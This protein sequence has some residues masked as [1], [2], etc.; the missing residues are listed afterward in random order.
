MRVIHGIWAHGALCLWAEDPDL[1]PVPSGVPSD[2]H[3]PQPH[4]FACQAAELADMLA[5]RPG[6]QEAV[7]KAVHDELILQLPTA[8][9]GPLASPELVRAEAPGVA[10]RPRPPGAGQA[11]PG[12]AGGLAGTGARLRPGRRVGGAQ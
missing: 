12:R 4:P 3:L 8:G 7:R 10:G 5:G 9:G 11:R 2:V 1:S 6:A